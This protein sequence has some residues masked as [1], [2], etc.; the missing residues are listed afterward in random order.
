[1][2]YLKNLTLLSAAG[3]MLI[4]AGCASPLACKDDCS[5]KIAANDHLKIGWGKRSIASDKP[6]PITGQFYLR[7]SQGVFT[8]VIASALAM[9]KGKDAAIFVSVD[10]VSVHFDQSDLLPVTNLLG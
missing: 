6:V 1:M 7:V 10:M 3:A 2:N 5:S 8:P 4:S 9:E